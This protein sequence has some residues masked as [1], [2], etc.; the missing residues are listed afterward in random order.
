[1]CS[2]QDSQRWNIFFLP[3][4]AGAHEWFKKINRKG[5]RHL[6]LDIRP[7]R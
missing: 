6:H 3:R 1:M 2:P 4:T 5:K 7:F